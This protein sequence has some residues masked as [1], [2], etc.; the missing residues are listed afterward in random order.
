MSYSLAAVSHEGLSSFCLTGATGHQCI[1]DDVDSA[2]CHGRRRLRSAFRDRYVETQLQSR[3]SLH[4][5]N[6]R[7]RP[8]QLLPLSETVF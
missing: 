1:C 5:V 7:A 8:T 4:L 3:S 2:A 6:Y